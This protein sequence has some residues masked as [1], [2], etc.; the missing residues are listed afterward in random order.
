MKTKFNWGLIKRPDTLAGKILKA[1][2]FP[3]CDF[4][5]AD[6]GKGWFYLCQG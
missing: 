6:N 2:Y 5:E 4:F 1:K 3:S